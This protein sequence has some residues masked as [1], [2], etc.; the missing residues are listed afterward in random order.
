MAMTRAGRALGR[1]IA[2]HHGTFISRPSQ[3]RVEFGFEK[4]LDKPANARP[5]PVFKGIEPII[6][7]KMLTFR[8]ACCGP[9]AIRC[10]GVISVGARTPVLVCFHKL[11]ITPPSNSTTPATAPPLPL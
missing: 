8:G 3:R 4:L 5:H 1:L 11:E 10:H 9:C 6:A 2:R 7:E